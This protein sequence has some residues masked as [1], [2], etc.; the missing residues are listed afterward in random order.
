MAHLVAPRELLV[1]GV[2]NLNDGSIVANARVFLSGCPMSFPYRVT[3]HLTENGMILDGP[4]PE[5]YP[6]CI[7]AALTFNANSHLEFHEALGGP[8]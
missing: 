1:D 5:I 8:R 7:I 2:A 3:G 6:G 4:A